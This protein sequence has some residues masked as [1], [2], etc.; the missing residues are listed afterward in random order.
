MELC[1]SQVVRPQKKTIERVDVMLQGIAAD[2]VGDELKYAM[3]LWYQSKYTLSDIQMIGIVSNRFYALREEKD[4]LRSIDSY[5]I[6]GAEKIPGNETLPMKRSIFW[7]I[8]FLMFMV[9][10]LAFVVWL[11]VPDGR[12]V[13]NDAYIDE[14]NHFAFSVPEGRA[15]FTNDNYKELSNENPQTSIISM[16]MS[17]KKLDIAVIAHDVNNWSDFPPVVNI[18]VSRKLPFKVDGENIKWFKAELEEQLSQIFKGYKI[19]S[20]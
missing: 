3:A 11:R 9:S 18:A 16:E 7:G 2:T 17:F 4:L 15:V 12:D 8:C 6:M 10:S 19:H 14:E 20:I 1:F 13:P 5:E